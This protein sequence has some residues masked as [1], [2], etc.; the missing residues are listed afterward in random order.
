M[1][2]YPKQLISELVTNLSDILVKSFNILK[3][4]CGYPNLELSDLIEEVL[5]ETFSGKMDKESLQEAINKVMKNKRNKRAR[6]IK[7]Y[8]DLMDTTSINDKD[9][10]FAIYVDLYNNNP[11]LFEQTYS[12][13]SLENVLDNKYKEIEAWE[14]NSEAYFIDFPAIESFNKTYIWNALKNDIAYDL[15]NIIKK[16][17]KGTLDNYFRQYPTELIEQPLFSPSAYDLVFKN[18]SGEMQEDF[19]IT[20]DGKTFLRTSLKEKY[21]AEV[22]YE[23]MDPDDIIVM[24]TFISH[25]G[26]DFY[27]TRSVTL[28]AGVIAK[29][30]CSNSNPSKW[31]YE[32]AENRSLKLTK[33]T[34]NY[35][36]DD[37]EKASYNFFDSVRIIPD[38]ET[39]KKTI[40]AFFGNLLYRTIVDNK[41][42]S[43]T[44]QSY[45]SLT[46]N[47][48]KIIYFALQRERISASLAYHDYIKKSLPG[49]IDYSIL[50]KEYDYSFFRS[51]VRFRY[52]NKK[53]NIKL[54][55]ESLDEFKSKGIA[56]KDYY[57]EKGNF[58]ITYYPLTQDEL[59]DLTFKR[60]S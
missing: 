26:K 47:L 30:L 12:N 3:R 7:R 40:I 8:H 51:I 5:R 11:L 56:I 42:I 22:C 13:Q 52:N 6:W 16:N 32:L 9:F 21:D 58:N 44:S 48:S 4:S 60:I 46:N 33:F 31:H 41:L 35:Y 24:N 39:G 2:N 10:P 50:S 49:D 37:G 57:I 1:S 23:T 29:A 25:A 27:E 45:D 59:D 18:V 38:Q 34:W 43:V 28:D 14:S 17:Y 55:T 53:K 19:F 15:S 54:I 36:K 20:D